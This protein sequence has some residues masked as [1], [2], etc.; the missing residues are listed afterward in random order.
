MS[1]RVLWIYEVFYELLITWLCWTVAGCDILCN[2]ACQYISVSSAAQPSSQ[3]QLSKATWP[4]GNTAQGHPWM[5]SFLDAF[6][7]DAFIMPQHPSI[8]HSLPCKPKAVRVETWQLALPSVGDQHRGSGVSRVPCGPSTHR[9]C[10]RYIWFAQQQECC[11]MSGR[12]TSWCAAG[13]G[14]GD[15]QGLQDVSWRRWGP[16][17]RWVGDATALEWRCPT[18]HSVLVQHCIALRGT[19]SWQVAPILVTAQGCFSPI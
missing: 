13:P 5:H 8:H 15:S 11:C 14:Q 9:P 3:P 4:G 17:E 19:T 1:P 6:Y 7:P 10:R 2:T 12:H 16:W 18:C